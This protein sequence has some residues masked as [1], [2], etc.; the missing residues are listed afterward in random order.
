MRK[1]LILISVL[2]FVGCGGGGN[3]SSSSSVPTDTIPPGTE[4]MD[5]GVVYQVSTGDQ[6]VKT[7]VDAQIR[8]KHVD[9]ETNSTIELVAGEANIVRSQ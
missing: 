7:S 2:L 4:K 9:G 8:V 3:S 5:A 1:I 6:V